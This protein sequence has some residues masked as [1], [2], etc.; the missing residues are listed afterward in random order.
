MRGRP[1]RA[2]GDVGCGAGSR[3]SRSGQHNTEG[4]GTAGELI[5]NERNS[6]DLINRRSA[7]VAKRAGA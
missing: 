6:D 5:G 2:G 3:G 1:S 4:C 7:G